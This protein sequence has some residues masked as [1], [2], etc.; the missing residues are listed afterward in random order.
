MPIRNIFWESEAVSRHCLATCSSSSLF[1]PVAYVGPALEEFRPGFKCFSPTCA[2]FLGHGDMCARGSI[3][4][5]FTAVGATFLSC[6]DQVVA[7]ILSNSLWLADG[8]HILPPI[9]QRISCPCHGNFLVPGECD[10]NTCSILCFLCDNATDM[11]GKKLC[12]P[13]KSPCI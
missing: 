11:H 7:L 13:W 5:N 6:W 8:R 2:S 12:Q 9:L 1:S 3:I 4:A 10:I